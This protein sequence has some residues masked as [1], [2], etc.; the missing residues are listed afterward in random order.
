MLGWVVTLLSC[1]FTWVLALSLTTKR[2]ILLG[3]IVLYLNLLSE[4]LAFPRNYVKKILEPCFPVT[5]CP[6]SQKVN[7]TSSILWLLWITSYYHVSMHW[8][9]WVRYFSAQKYFMFL[10]FRNALSHQNTWYSISMNVS[11]T[12]LKRHSILLS[13]VF[14]ILI[15]DVPI[16]L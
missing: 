3:L 6:F 12:F 14:S 2:L 8:T 10:Y 9:S 7:F 13:T 5:W 11:F 4:S 1:I 15:D 16:P